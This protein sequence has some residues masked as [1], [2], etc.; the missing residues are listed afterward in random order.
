M[1]L[2][3]SNSQPLDSGLLAALGPFPGGVS[4]NS[5]ETAPL[6]ARLMAESRSS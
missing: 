1:P 2:K 4:T 5:A 3:R 6:A